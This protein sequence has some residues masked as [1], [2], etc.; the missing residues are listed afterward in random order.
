MEWA[1]GSVAW[2]AIVA[3]PL[4][5][6]GGMVRRVLTPV[7]V[8]ALG[9]TTTSALR[10]WGL[11]RVAIA[12]GV[13]TVATASVERLGTTT[14]VPF[15]RYR[16]TDRLRPAIAGVPVVVPLAWLAMAAPARETAHAALGAQSTPT[17]RV[18]LGA[19]ALTAWDLFLDP[20]MVAEGF[21]Q[22]RR[23]GRYRGVPLTNFAGWLLTSAAVMAFLEWALPPQARAEPVL[24]AEYA[25][26]AAMETAGFA[27]FFRDPLVAT[28]GGVAMLPFAAAGVA[29]V[30]GDRRVGGG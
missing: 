23:V 4:A 5:R 8:G 7:V 17:R 2:L 20:Q 22:W 24:V 9:I 10:P 30:V 18:A 3:Y 6:R 15:G 21:W 19:V 26:M 16:Y 28:V 25:G 11:R 12:A 29:R 14:G 13:V 27:V 1:A